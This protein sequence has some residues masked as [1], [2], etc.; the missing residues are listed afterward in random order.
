MAS[1]PVTFLVLTLIISESVLVA[2]VGVTVDVG[3]PGRFLPTGCRLP[4]QLPTHLNSHAKALAGGLYPI[5][6]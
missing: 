4:D 6:S 2:A 1:I 3:E 5:Q